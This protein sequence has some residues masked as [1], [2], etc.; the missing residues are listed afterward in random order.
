MPAVSATIVAAQLPTVNAADDAAF[1]TAKSSSYKPA[2]VATIV[3]TVQPA[4]Q[5]TL[6]TTIVATL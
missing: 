2:V 1:G 4:V 5:T 3:A 6:E